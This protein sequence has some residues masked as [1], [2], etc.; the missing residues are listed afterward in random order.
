MFLF[1]KILKKGIRYQGIG[2]KIVPLHSLFKNMIMKN[3]NI[4]KSLLM[5]GVPIIVGQL[6]IIAQQFADTIMVGQ[7]GTQELA[8]AGFVN[9]VF[10]LVVY[11]I[12]G[13][14]YASTP[15]IGAYFGSNDHRS[16]VR[17]LGESLVVNLGVS[18][19]VAAALVALLCNIEILRQPEEILP[20]AIPY[21]ITLLVSVPIMALFNALKQ[22]S[23]SIGQ[24]KMPM[25]IMIA[26]NVL[27]IFLNWLLIFGVMGCPRLGLLGAGLA[28]LAARLFCLIALAVAITFGKR[29]RD[30]FTQDGEKLSFHNSTPTLVGMKHLLFIGIPISI[31]LGLETSSFNACAIFMGWLGAIPLAAHQVMCTISTLC[32]QI[33][34]GIG[35]AA[36]VMISHFRGASDWG[37]VRRT[38]TTAFFL[39][40]GIV[41]MMIVMIYVS[42]MPLM[43]I[44]TTNE[45]VITAALALLP[46][47]FLYQ[48][49]DTMQI[50]FANALRG[51]EQVK[52]MMLYAFIAYM[53]VS[54]PMS[55]FF[56]F[57]LKW[58][59]V[60]VWMG[61][62]FGLTTA[63]VLFYCD[64]RK[65]LAKAEVTALH[66][67]RA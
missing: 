57:I 33:V 35:A 66:Y 26:S 60:G 19:F 12:L 8:A 4:V 11:F 51:I 38:S 21:Y 20:I 6:G 27:N 46:C 23:D 43:H 52:R 7:Y 14:S 34:Y 37:N 64:Y 41:G 3:S 53:M 16:V 56:A 28:T 30:A 10:N 18:L 2:K 44:F 31:Q 58:G 36:S 47:F 39:S 13:I 62:P 48:F 59:T 54:I 50:V 9:N 5:L 63:G 24:T 42:R 32:F 45:E 55:Y 61:M 15:V 40:L 25:W 65:G 29:Y 22:F 17:S 67:S 1:A 49:G